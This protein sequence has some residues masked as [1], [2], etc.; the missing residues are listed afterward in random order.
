MPALRFSAIAF[1]IFLSSA[2]EACGV[3]VEK[4]GCEQS[5]VRGIRRLAVFGVSREYKDLERSGDSVDTAE[6]SVFSSDR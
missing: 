4:H 3:N 6:F 2:L 1:L 5:R